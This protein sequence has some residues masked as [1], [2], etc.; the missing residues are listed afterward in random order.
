MA[1][2]VVLGV[3]LHGWMQGREVSDRNGQIGEEINRSSASFA[4]ISI[5]R[6]TCG[7][8]VMPAGALRQACVRFI[9]SAFNILEIDHLSG[10]W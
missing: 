1:V 8:W 7:W 6:S 2:V 10:W 9:N 3:I 5:D 4:S